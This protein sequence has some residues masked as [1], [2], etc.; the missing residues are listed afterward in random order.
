[1]DIALPR[2]SK[3]CW[4]LAIAFSLLTLGDLVNFFDLSRIAPYTEWAGRLRME[5]TAS[6]VV[7]EY[8]DAT[9]MMLMISAV[10][11]ASFVRKK[12]SILG[13]VVVALYT[14]P[15]IMAGQ[16][17]QVVYGALLIAMLVHYRIKPIRFGQAILLGVC[18]YVVATMINHVRKTAD[19]SVMFSDGINLIRDDPE[20]LL[21]ARNG[22]LIGPPTSLLE[23]MKGINNGNLSFSYGYTYLSEASTFIPRFLYPGR[24]LPLAEVYMESFYAREAVQG[25]GRAMFLLTDG[26][27]AFGYAGVILEMLAFGW[28]VSFIYRVFRS[29]SHSAPVVLIYLNLIIPII[30]LAIR[31]TLLGTIKGI[32]MSFA[33]FAIMLFFSYRGVQRKPEHCP[34]ELAGSPG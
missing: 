1:V 18:L 16:K 6:S 23:V 10:I 21:P 2:F 13:F 5:R 24:P 29:N 17:T 8:L 28:V 33:P 20:I 12:L 25:R 15:S 3:A 30:A 34:P 32:L 4:F 14:I 9:A 19:L 22:E 7:F 26:Y 11:L 27:W 31:G